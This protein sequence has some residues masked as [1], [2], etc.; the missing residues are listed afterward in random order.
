[1]MLFEEPLLIATAP[2]HILV[3]LGIFFI[4]AAA[5]LL[6][7]AVEQGIYPEHREWLAELPQRLVRHRQL[8]QRWTY[9]TFVGLRSA[10]L[11]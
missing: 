2:D 1:M 8:S 11:S 4:L 7:Q 9:Y 6:C 10:T 3:G 5:T